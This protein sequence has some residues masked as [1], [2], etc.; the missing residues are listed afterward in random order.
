M[1]ALTAVLGVLVLVPVGGC[2]QLQLGAKPAPEGGSKQHEDLV[3]GYSL[4]ADTLGDE[5]QLKKLKFL[6]TIT[7][8][9]PARQVG[10]IMDRLAAVSQKRSAEL[11]KLRRL[12][13]DVSGKPRTSSP[14]GD[15]I[16][17]VAEDL[18]MQEML[19][20]KGG[21][22]IRFLVLQAQA[23]RMVAAMSKAISGFDP[24]AERVKWLL[25]VA[26]EYE[27][28]RNELIGAIEKRV[29]DKQLDK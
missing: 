27:G 26:S 18:G 3:M 17:A 1:T 13:P 14:V 8:R 5:S 7:L 15:A 25:G 6:K 28:I 19:S 22:N 12:A 2:G 29:S 16:T 21:F 11:E 4:L 24:N 9:G 20:R 10:E 23:A